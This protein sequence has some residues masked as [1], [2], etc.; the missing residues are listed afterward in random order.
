MRKVI[1]CWQYFAS[2]VRK[3]RLMATGLS[4]NLEP[5]RIMQR[6]LFIYLFVWNLFFSLV[7]Y[8][9]GKQPRKTFVSDKVAS[10]K[11]LRAFACC[12]PSLY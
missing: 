8:L 10:L 5:G 12:M 4:L 1:I 11:M 3:V 2:N 9:R 6:T 7:L